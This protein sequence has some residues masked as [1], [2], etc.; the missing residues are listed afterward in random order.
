MISRIA[1]IIFLVA[2]GINLIWALAYT[3]LI[4]GIAALIA[5]VAMVI[6]K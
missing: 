1:T 6:E 2:I 5:G 4:A 3:A